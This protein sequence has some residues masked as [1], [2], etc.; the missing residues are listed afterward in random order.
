MIEEFW[1]VFCKEGIRKKIRGFV[2]HVDTGAAKPVCCK[3]PRYDK[4]ESEIIRRLCHCLQQN[5]MIEPDDG[6]WGDLVVLAQKPHQQKVPWWDFAWRLCLSFRKLNQIT[7][8]F[9][10][11]QRVLQ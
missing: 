2:F 7:R 4:Y 9:A 3:V 11:P 5:G 8:P 1:D 6:P 10:F